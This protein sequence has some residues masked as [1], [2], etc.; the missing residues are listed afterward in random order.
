[1]NPVNRC[2]PSASTGAA[3]EEQGVGAGMTRL[4]GRGAVVM[5]EWFAMCGREATATVQHPILGSVPV[6]ERCQKKATS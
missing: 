5:C 1:M 6:C 4:Q 2:G 3:I